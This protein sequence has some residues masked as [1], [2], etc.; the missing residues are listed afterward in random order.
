MTEGG[1]GTLAG[2]GLR[3]ALVTS[4][5]NYI[6]DGVALTLNRLVAYLQRH[7]A[8]V[9]VAAPVG[10][11]AA[12]EHAGD[13]I[14]A[15]SAPI[16]FRPEYRLGLGLTSSMRRR[17]ARFDPDVMH[18]ATPDLLGRQA[19]AFARGRK[20][21]V[22]ASYHTR[23]EAYLKDYGLAFLEDAV[24]NWIRRFYAAF[25]EVYVPS[26]S[27]AGHL[28]EA[29]FA[30]N[31]RLWPRGVDTDRF[32]PGKRD[33]RWREAL[34]ADAAT[35]M[36]VYVGRLVREKRL[37]TLIGALSRLARSGAPHRAVIVGDGPDRAALER[38]LP[39]AVFTGF[40]TGESLATA[41]ASADI[42]LFP[43]D[44]ESFGSVTLEAMASGLPAVAADAT[45]SR[46]LVDHGLTGF[47]AAPGD[48]AAFAAALAR[49]AADPALRAS[50]GA[51]ARERSLAF[52]WD[53]A[54]GAIMQ[55][56][57]TLAG[58]HQALAVA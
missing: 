46:C 7:G 5:Y 10:R 31:I 16:P 52:S 28:R 40:L 24:G 37:D 54:M 23:Y 34:G 38:A 51:A 53:R 45:G 13:L 18:I 6:A 14:F 1:A 2:R 4:S 47:L 43:S 57:Q 58:H 50:M 15:P 22:V 26:A 27:M 29:G 30:D 41:Y 17:L 12:L 9:L 35:P 32:H 48:G 36:I 19:L 25:D 49:L 3:L 11:R 33:H 44:T 20:L 42:F 55:R 8:E 39:G 56:Y 21:P